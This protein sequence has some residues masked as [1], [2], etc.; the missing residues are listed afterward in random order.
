MKTFGQSTIKKLKKQMPDS[1]FTINDGAEIFKDGKKIGS[2]NGRTKT[3]FYEAERKLF[4]K[5]GLDASHTYG[6]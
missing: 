4:K 2:I 1:E 5:L 6:S 3:E